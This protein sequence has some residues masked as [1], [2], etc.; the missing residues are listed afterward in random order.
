MIKELS[1]DEYHDAWHRLNASPLQAWQWGELKKETW[2]VERLGVYDK[3]VLISIGTVFL[4]KFPFSALTKIF[5]FEKLAYIPRGIAVQDV[6]YFKQI[7]EE[8]GNYLK[9][10]KVAFILLDP[11]RDF[12]IRN[13]NREFEDSLKAEGWRVAGTSIEPNQTDVLRIDKDDEDLLSAM[14]PKWRR[15]IKKAQRDGVKIGEV[16]DRDAVDKF[17]SVIKD[18]EKNTKFK[19]RKKRY[20]RK[21][22]DVL[23]QEG[24]IRIFV[25]T[26]KDEVIASYLVLV[27]DTAAFEIYGGA[28]SR[29]RDLEASYLLKWEIIRIMRTGGRKFYDHWGVAPKD[30][31]K[32]SLSGIS[33]FKNGFGGKYVQ[34]LPQYVKVFKTLAYCGYRLFGRR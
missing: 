16:C 10:K 17:Y 7:L 34:F 33:Y 11:D 6:K 13:W 4:R 2:E 23:S 32:H 9:G 5:G 26:Y 1:K 8:L 28:A 24:L 25:A 21:M 31:D 3:E 15:N 12:L 27:T 14:K 18:V 30:S 29:G 20:F 19:V 22:W